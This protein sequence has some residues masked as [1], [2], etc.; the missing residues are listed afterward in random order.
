MTT[1]C[2]LIE[3]NTENETLFDDLIAARF[4]FSVRTLT[5]AMFEITFTVDELRLRDLEAIMAWYV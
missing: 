2:Y 3:W 5:D 1:K 4:D